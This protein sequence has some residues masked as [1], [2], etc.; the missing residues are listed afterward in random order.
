MA[1]RDFDARFA[2]ETPFFA[3]WRHV[4]DRE[5]GEWSRRYQEFRLSLSPKTV[6]APMDTP[7]G[8]QVLY[9]HGSWFDEYQS[10]GKV[11]EMG[12]SGSELL[13]AVSLS[14]GDVTKYVQGGIETLEA[15]IN[16][17]LSIGFNFLDNPIGVWKMGKGTREK[18][19]RFTV[20]AIKILEVSLT[21]VPRLRRA[22][23]LGSA[24][25]DEMEGQDD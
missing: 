11:A 24:K 10:V 3:G 25:R 20:G 4:Y 5:A 12:I 16:A 17:G 19:D 1:T 21:P 23:L 18:P 9:Q 8:V 22:G 15:G 6:I 7:N 14:E 2:D 13:G